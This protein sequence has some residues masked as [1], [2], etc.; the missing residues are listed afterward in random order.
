MSEPKDDERDE[1]DEDEEEEE[2]SPPPPK[3]K[4][5][6]AS[7]SS[8]KS[9]GGRDKVSASASKPAL[10]TTERAV[11]IGIIAL[12]VGG[13]GGWFGQVQKTKAAL[14]AEIAAAP[15]GSGAPAG[16]C[17]AWQSKICSGTGDQSAACQEAKGAAELL[18]PTTCEAALGTVPE[19]LAK[20][21]AGRAS[22]D[23]LVTKICADLTPGSK[24]CDM[25]KQ[26]TPSFPTERCDQM[27]KS[28]DK[29]I[30]ELKQMDQGGGMQM[31]GPRMQMPPGGMPP[32]G[33]PPG[34]MP[35]GAQPG[36]MPPGGMP[37]S[38]VPHITLPQ[39][40]PHP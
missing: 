39:N 34:G 20:V 1:L 27:L 10:I 7:G 9:A 31:G 12:A 32:G 36:A 6:A 33:M 2:E 16:P 40:A 37:H 8:S 13:L 23:K 4:S 14:R 19:T 15:A 22:C 25:V 35:P 26:R 28:Y 5:K 17:G 11:A 38:G 30:G 24:T 3:A 29:V 18:L 21:K